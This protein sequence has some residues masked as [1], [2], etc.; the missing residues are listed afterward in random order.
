VLSLR[1]DRGRELFQRHLPVILEVA[2]RVARQGRLRAEDAE[3]FVAD[4]TLRLLE[5]DCAILRRF[6]GRSSLRT[7]LLRVVGR[8]L[9]DERIRKWGRW[10]PS[11]EAQR[12]GPLAIQLERLISRD[13]LAFGE[14]VESLRTNQ[15]VRE[16]REQLWALH[17]R[18]PVRTRRRLV[19]MNQLESAPARDQPEAALIGERESARAA[20]AFRR[21]VTRLAPEDRL[22]LT[23]HFEHGERLATIARRRGLD[24]KKLYRRFASLLKRLRLD[25]ESQGVTAATV[26]HIAGRID[27]DPRWHVSGVDAV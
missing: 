21:A 11:L 15:Q 1:R 20:V 4:V 16:S 12:L 5:D 10:R 13:G 9:L 26:G 2:R 7:F 18:L 23:Q 14:A 24:Q 22:L 3:E 19:S 6:E 25:L 17:A 8:F 27:V